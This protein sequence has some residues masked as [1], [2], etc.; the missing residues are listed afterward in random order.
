[1]FAP[2]H[3]H[4]ADPAKSLEADYVIVGAG[5]AGMAFADSLLGDSAHSM[6]IV[7]RR[8]Q[9]GGHWVDSYPFIRLHGPS[10][11]YGVN[12]RPLGE[13]AVE[14]GGWND[15]LMQLA[16]GA[17]ICAYF[18]R[19][20]QDHLLPSGRVTYLPMTELGQGGV[21]RSLVDGRL[22]QLRARRKWVDATVA[23]TQ[24]PA[25]HPPRFSVADGVRWTTPN[26][27]VRQALPAP[28]HVI[29]GGGKTGIDVALWLLGQG[30]DP[31][32]ITW[33]RPREAWL[34]N[35]ALV[36]P[37]GRGLLATVS[38]NAQEMEAAAAAESVTG[39]FARLERA[40]LLRRIDREVTPTMFR[41]AIV[42]DAE[43]AQLRRIRHVVRGAHVLAIEPRRIV[44]TR[45]TVATTPDALHVHCSAAGLPRPRHEPVFQRG[46]IVLQYV[47]RC[48]PCF[49]AALIA[50]LEATLDDDEARNALC[51]PVAPPEV[52]L[53]WLRMHLRSARNQQRWSKSPALRAWFARSRLDPM[54]G[55]IERALAGPEAP[56]LLD[57]LERYRRALPAGLERLAQLLATAP[58]VEAVT[59]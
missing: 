41:C 54:A 51:E 19:V 16:S 39:L 13:D 42:S 33:I 4:A 21:A 37:S 18:D 35:R 52:P 15:G 47:R 55:A 57:A 50:R 20:M 25:T 5:A 29:V 10:A 22:V 31:D 43:L 53:D 30:V 49:S 38:A 1:M 59:A 32:S 27:L 12:S 17:E 28:R 40:E 2:H 8:H 44:L 14:H 56:A 26:D 34:L 11:H 36:Q 23:D 45:G 6:I 48:S 46:R 7:D 9:P 58:A 24:V 3:S